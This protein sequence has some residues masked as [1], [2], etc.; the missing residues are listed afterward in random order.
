MSSVHDD[1]RWLSETEMRAW[2]SYIVSTL[3]L[4]HRLHRDLAERHDVSLTDYEVLVCLSSREDRRMRMT[5]LASMLGSTKSRLSHQVGRMES[6][7]VVRRVKDPEDK[8][9]VVAELTDDGFAVLEQSAPTHVEGVRKHLIDLL[10]TEEKVAMGE[11]F[12]RVLE[13][14]TELDG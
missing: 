7:G 9:G 11:A 14:L 10:T 12:S 1:V 13:H 4:R 5:E 3:M 8:R 2:R 6:D